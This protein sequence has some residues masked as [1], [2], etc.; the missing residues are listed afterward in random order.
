MNNKTKQTEGFFTLIELL[1]VIAIIAILASML[2]PALNQ[3]REK[4]KAINCTSQLK[5]M[6]LANQSV[7][8]DYDGRIAQSYAPGLYNKTTEEWCWYQQLYPFLNNSEVFICPSADPT[9]LSLRT[10]TSNG[11]DTDGDG[12]KEDFST[13][14]AM[15][16]AIGGYYD[17]PTVTIGSCFNK[18]SMF[19][20][21]SKTVYIMDYHQK[22][23]FLLANLE[24]T[25]VNAGTQTYIFR[26]SRYV[27]ASFIDGH[28]SK[29]FK[30]TS[31][32]WSSWK[33]EYEWA[34]P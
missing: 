11:V 14:Y 24:P 20:K 2:L 33:T 13:N 7:A 10:G 8:N 31:G 3:A 18:L 28:V 25:T 4:A 34:N 17:S 26:H 32:T 5:Q 12:V 19:T 30:P 29:I 9:S 16:A 15:N 21:P 1:V 23:Q 27:N 6:G 22:F